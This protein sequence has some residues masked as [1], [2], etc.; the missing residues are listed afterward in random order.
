M[1][2]THNMAN[3]ELKNAALEQT[4]DQLNGNWETWKRLKLSVYHGK[5][6]AKRSF[7]PYHPKTKSFFLHELDEFGFEPNEKLII[8]MRTLKKVFGNTDTNSNRSKRINNKLSFI[9]VKGLDH[10]KANKNIKDL[11]EFPD[12]YWQALKAV[13]DG[14]RAKKLKPKGTV[15]WSSKDKE[16]SCQKIF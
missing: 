3:L 15:D 13:K 2:L 6:L 10:F 7:K 14:Q 12:S 16:V 1:S 11:I 4:P 9:R 8:V 5:K